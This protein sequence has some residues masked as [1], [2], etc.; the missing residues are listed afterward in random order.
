MDLKKVGRKKVGPLLFKKKRQR[1]RKI[2]VTNEKIMHLQV[3]K[4]KTRCFFYFCGSGGPPLS[5]NLQHQ[6]DFKPNVESLKR[7]ENGFAT[8][9]FPHIFDAVNQGPLFCKVLTK[10]SKEQIPL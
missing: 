8:L 3:S 9:H 6:K 5:F 7:L 10:E 4:P 2:L 1:L